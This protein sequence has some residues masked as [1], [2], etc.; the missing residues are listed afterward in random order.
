[1]FQTALLIEHRNMATKTTPAQALGVP[2]DITR[3][4]GQPEM[5]VKDEKLLPVVTV[6]YIPELSHQIQEEDQVTYLNLPKIPLRLR[7]LP[8]DLA[9]LGNQFV[10]TLVILQHLV[11]QRIFS[12]YAIPNLHQQIQDYQ[13]VH[14][15]T[16][17]AATL[18]QLSWSLMLSSEWQVE[19]IP[20]IFPVAAGVWE[21]LVKKPYLD[22]LKE[23]K[24]SNYPA[25]AFLQPTKLP[26]GIV[27]R[28]AQI[29]SVAQPKDRWV[30]GLHLAMLERLSWNHVMKDTAESMSIHHSDHAIIG[31]QL[32]EL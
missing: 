6:D 13:I 17:P 21:L 23:S 1:M 16:D 30:F 22:E 32:Y 18:Q 2:C 15:Q 10:D 31:S 3:E 20:M 29:R 27:G 25:L 14:V 26:K 11:Y 4:F 7:S 5:S 19:N 9:L 24:S 28:I 8:S 12:R